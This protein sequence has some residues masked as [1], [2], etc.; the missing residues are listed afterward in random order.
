MLLRDAIKGYLLSRKVQGCSEKTIE[1]YRQKLAHLCETLQEE[2]GITELGQV[3]ITH[4]RLFVDKLQH[5]KSGANNPYTP[6]KSANLSDLTIKGYVQVIRGFFRWCVSDDPP[7]LERNPAAALKM[8]KVG[9][10]LIKTFEPRHI[11]AM[12]AACDIRTVL[13]FRDYVIML[14]LL[15]T[16]IRLAELCSL[17][18]DRVFLKVKTEPYIKVLGKGRKEREVGLHQSTAELLW[19]YIH[20]YRRYH[21]KSERAIFM[22]RYGQPLTPSG[23]GQLLIEIKKRAGIEDVRVSPHTFRHTFARM[24]LEQDGE[25]YKLSRL[26]G[27]SKVAVTERYLEDFQSREARRGQSEHSPLSL[28]AGKSRRGFQKQKTDEWE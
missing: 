23:V 26:L 27:H 21:D 17:T 20:H 2:N 5:T 7:L 9:K 25:V 3:T 1:W 6:T 16:G 24:Y 13:G 28:F 12:L 22:N 18:V 10:Y 11:E 4:L 8:P 15:D 19:K 14:L